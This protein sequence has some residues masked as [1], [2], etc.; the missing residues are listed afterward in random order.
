MR[1]TPDTLVRAILRGMDAKFD[2]LAT[3]MQD[4]KHRMT[5]MAR[6]MG[7]MRVDMTGIPGRID[8][9]DVRIDRIERRLDILS[10]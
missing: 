5:S 4:R 8:R 10:T 1:D 3:D 6:Q 9:L 2:R 7:G